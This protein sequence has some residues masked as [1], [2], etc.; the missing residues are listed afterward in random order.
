MIVDLR[1]EQKPGGPD[2]KCGEHDRAGRLI[3]RK[4]EAID[5]I[6]LHQTARFYGVAPYQVLAA[7][8]DKRLAKWRRGLGVH[9]HVTSWTNGAF[10]AAYPLRAYVW[11][12]NGA[13]G[14]SIGLE[15]EGLYNGR[16]GGSDAE[17]T[18]ETI[19][20]ARE[21]VRWIVEAARSEG[22]TIRYML[23]HRQYSRTRQAD[24]GWRLWRDVALWSEDALGLVTLPDLVDGEGRPIPRDWDPRRT[25]AY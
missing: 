21:A 20:T 11:H 6:C 4:P 7:K 18:D 22:I 25:A 9:A 12:G 5:A 16:P 1:S 19:A 23:A 15:V 14:R 17:P 8:G 10:T 24:P 3:I 2:P 13:N